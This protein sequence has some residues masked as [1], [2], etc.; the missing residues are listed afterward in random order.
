MAREVIFG[1]VEDAFPHVGRG[2]G[3]QWPT[4]TD[5]LAFGAHDDWL[6]KNPDSIPVYAAFAPSRCVR[7]VFIKR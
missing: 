7:Q 6:S 2:V 4:P 5:L 3:L 1:G